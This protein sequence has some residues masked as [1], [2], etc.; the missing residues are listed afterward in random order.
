MGL[1]D[2]GGLRCGSGY[3]ATRCDPDELGQAVSIHTQR[4]SFHLI[5]LTLGVIGCVCWSG[6]NPV[7]SA[8]N[9]TSGGGPAVLK[10]CTTGDYEPLTYRDPATDQYSGIDIDM[11]TSLANYLGREP[12]FVA[13]T[14]PTLM[15][16]VTR[17]GKCDIAMGGISDAPARAELADLTM[18]Y[19]FNGKVALVPAASAERFQS[20]DQINQQG[21]RVIENPGGTNEKFARQ[22]LPNAALTIWPDNTSIFEQLSAGNADVMITDA[23]EAIYQA[24]RHPE[25]VAV[26]PE[27]PYT[28]DRK[29]YMLPEG[30]QLTGQ[31]NTWLGQA[32]AD[33]TFDSFYDQW[34]H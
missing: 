2:V 18:P 17:L 25:L 9:F 12:V 32:L 6:L 30:S 8:T 16:D 11:A 27:Q 34:I 29:A 24:K 22:N 31:V 20:I 5:A 33:G 13:T 4:A 15:K 26:H 21:V 14:W 7:A 10:I 28:T 19:L 23:I 1:L 3:R